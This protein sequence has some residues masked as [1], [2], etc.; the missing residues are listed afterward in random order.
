MLS[1]FVDD[2][3]NP[4][5]LGDIPLA[6]K[7]RPRDF[8]EFIGQD[9]II[10]KDKPLRRAIENDELRSIILWGPPGSGKTTLAKIIAHKTKAYF[11]FFSAAT[12]GVADLKKIVKQ[13]EERKIL[14]NQKTILFVDEIHRFN[15]AQQDAFLPFVEKGTII[16]IGATTQNP[17]FDI[18]SPLLSRSL[19]LVLNS[20]TEK[21]MTQ[22]LK[23]ALNDRERGLGDYPVEIS[24]DALK[25]IINFANG[26]ARVA[27]NVLEFVVLNTLK[28][29]EGKII[30]DE[31]ILTEALQKKILRYDKGG[32]EHY[33][34]ISAFIKSMRDSNPDAA[35]YWLARMIDAGED[36]RFIARRMLIFASEDIGNID[37]KAI[38][39]AASVAYAVE[40][41]GM[42]EAQINLAQAAA[43]LA[44]APKDNASYKGL[45]RALKD[46]KEFGNLP[47]PLHLRNAVT[48]LMKD[49]GYGKDYQYPHNFEKH[50]TDQGEKDL[51]PQLRDRRY[52]QPRH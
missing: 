8:D 7:M 35:L 42:P 6:E 40:H 50:I 31:K 22:I 15:K 38:M 37:P 45:L 16:L 29:K 43:Y 28:N 3:N 12:A 26:D 24:E 33:N 10:G 27:L 41:V 52:Y 44:C 51:P 49:L 11:D 36:P 21:E 14:K 20:L 39:V 48:S 19:V 23:N 32:E 30:I 25:G 1:L 2:L 5:H 13:A 4:D 9:K 17:S 47:V 34:T 18:I 46:V